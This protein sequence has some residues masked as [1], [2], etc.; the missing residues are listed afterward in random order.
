MSDSTTPRAA[1]L[2]APSWRNSRIVVGVL[3]VLLS[4]L[5]G[6][7]AVAA[8]DDS[9]PMYAAADTLVP[10]Q[11]ITS[12]QLVRV[13]VRLGDVSNRYVTA[14]RPIAADAVATREVRGGELLLKTSV[15]HQ[16]ESA[17]KPVMLPVERDIAGVLVTGSVVDVWVNTK[18]NTSGGEAFGTPV[19]VLGSAPVSRAA[20]TES[21]R[22]AGGRTTTGVQVMVPADQI[23]KLI[24]AVDQGA[25]VT[26]VPVLGS[27]LRSQG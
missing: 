27:P 9:T 7:R 16:S 21:S 26:L 22:F 20:D 2:T 1:R 15:G 5:A 18:T 4:T 10:G 19:K 12:A 8:T 6:A 25:R 13:D 14:D 24:A 3:L 17:L 11:P 23:E